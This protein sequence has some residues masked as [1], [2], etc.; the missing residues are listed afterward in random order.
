M[1]FY[2]KFRVNFA[3]SIKVTLIKKNIDNEK[4]DLHKLV[5]S[6]WHGNKEEDCVSHLRLVLLVLHVY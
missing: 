5:S 1:G 4:V 6:D 3:I 2:V